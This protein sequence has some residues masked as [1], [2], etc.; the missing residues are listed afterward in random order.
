[1]RFKGKLFD[2]EKFTKVVQT[3]D[4]IAKTCVVHLTEKKIEFIISEISEGIA[5]WSGINAGSLFDSYKIESK[6]NNE[7]AFELSLDNLLR[8]LKSCVKASEVVFKLSKKNDLPFLSILIERRLTNQ[9]MKIVQDI[10]VAILTAA[11]LSQYTE[12]QL[13]DPEVYILVPPLRKLRNV[14]DRMKNIDNYLIIN[15]NMS[16]ELSL[17]VQTESVSVA[18]FYKNLE[19]PQ[20]EGRSPPKLDP[21]K[22][23][24]VKV[25]IRKFSRFLYS[26][27]V[28]PTNVILCIVPERAIVLHVILDDLYLTYYIPV[29]VQGNF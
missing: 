2:L 18:T 7:I 14:V 15:A 25:D 22:E 16:G 21:H 27:Q 8:A 19:H 12:P 3:V 9:T 29:Y 17:K 28:S 24:E 20:I 26:Y 1:M 13:P 23:A 4:K 5:V 11:Q 10:P 6:N